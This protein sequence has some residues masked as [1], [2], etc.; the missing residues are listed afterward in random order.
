[1]YNCPNLNECLWRYRVSRC[2]DVDVD[3]VLLYDS[4]NQPTHPLEKILF[5]KC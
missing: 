2:A 1:M 3:A 5:E 4:L